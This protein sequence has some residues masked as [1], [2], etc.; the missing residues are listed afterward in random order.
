MGTMEQGIYRQLRHSIMVKEDTK[1]MA[2]LFCF[3]DRSQ[4]KLK[5]DYEELQYMGLL[6]IKSKCLSELM[7]DTCHYA[8]N[9]KQLTSNDKPQKN[10]NGII[11]KHEQ[12]FNKNY[13]KIILKRFGDQGQGEGHVN[14]LNASL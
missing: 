3:Q 2:T 6:Q 4:A 10:G 14:D 7:K 11:P 5:Q 1:K 12:W 9:K 8:T 13:N